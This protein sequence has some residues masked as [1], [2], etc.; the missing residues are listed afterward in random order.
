MSDDIQASFWGHVGE[1]RRSLIYSFFAVAVG[2]I[3]C[4]YFYQDIFHLLTRPLQQKGSVHVAELKTLRVANSGEDDLHY[5]HEGTA[6]LIPAK[7]HVDLEQSVP[8]GGLVVF[9]PIEGMLIALKVCLWTGFVASSPFWVFFLMRFIHPALRPDEKRC[10]LPFL[11]LS[12]LFMGTGG[13]LAYF[14]TIPLANNYLQSFNA[15]LGINLWSLNQYLDYTLFLLLANAFAFEIAVVLLL[16]VHFGILSAA[17]MASKRRHM[18]VLAFILGALLTPPDI[19]TQ[20]MLAIPLIIL[21]EL[22][23]LYAKVVSRG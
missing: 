20:V 8:N 2:V 3:V 14:V 19:L 21:Y 5:L 9:G 4:F 23:L 16:L 22:T 15:T 17:M 6:Y 18:I 13:L 7:S 10:I 12:V 11:L 1:L